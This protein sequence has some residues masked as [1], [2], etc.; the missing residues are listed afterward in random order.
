[1]RVIVTR[2]EPEAGRWVDQFRSRN[3]DA[4]ALPLIDIAPVHD[5][6]SLRQ[7]WSTVDSQAAVMF[8][9]AAAVR[10]FFAAATAA[11][12]ERWSTVAWATGPGTANALHA[13]GVAADRIAQ[14]PQDAAQFD[15]EAL[16]RVVQGGVVPGQQVLIVRGA[17]ADGE[18]A[19][20][21]WLAGRL[22][23]AGA[24]VRMVAAYRRDLPAW[25]AAQHAL[26]RE[27]A[28]D[29]G[30]VWL[31]SSSEAIGNLERLQPGQAWQG[32]RAVATHE[33]IAQAARRA[34]FG[35]VCL[36]RPT[37]DALC[38]ALESFG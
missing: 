7:A 1:V 19:G 2:P 22:A 10:H 15:S 16:W 12:R 33:R 23:E 38:T 36:S 24:T 14:P 21:D 28:A 30:A 32:S 3:I 26:A 4:V 6:A 18:A 5:L 37:V 35:V 17:G 27:A 34:G 13:E 31:F 20:R 9:S 8:V 11:Q 29:P 25:T